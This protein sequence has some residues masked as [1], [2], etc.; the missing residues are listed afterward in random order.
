MDVW[1]V[2]ILAYELLVGYPPF[3][4]DSR[5]KTYESIM[6]ADPEFP[7]WVSP[8]AREFILAALSKVSPAVT[9][10]STRLTLH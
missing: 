7:A 5:M 9:N 1:A 6:N 4:K 2:G 8:N 10:I 3:E